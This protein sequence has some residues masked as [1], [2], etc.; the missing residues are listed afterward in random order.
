MIWHEGTIGA[1]QLKMEAM[2]STVID[3]MVLEVIAENF[4]KLP[5]IDFAEVVAFG[6]EMAFTFTQKKSGTVLESELH[7]YL[8]AELHPEKIK[9]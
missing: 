9:I 3:D 1:E 7:G 4:G 5:R 8:K 6:I 2:D